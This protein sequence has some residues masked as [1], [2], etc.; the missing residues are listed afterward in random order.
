MCI[1]L[2]CRQTGLE[3]HTTGVR[4][5]QNKSDARYLLWTFLVLILVGDEVSG[6]NPFLTSLLHLSEQLEEL[7]VV[8]AEKQ[9]IYVETKWS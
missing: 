2:Q 4:L 1:S 7:G 8:Y 6:W 5:A 3:P 9:A